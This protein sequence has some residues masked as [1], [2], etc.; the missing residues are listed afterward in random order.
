[1]NVILGQFKPAFP[2]RA[3]GVSVPFGRGAFTLIEL[4]VVIAIIAI[5]AALLLPTLARAKAKAKRIQCLSNQRQLATAAMLY[6]TDAQGL[7]PANGRSDYPDP[8]RRLWVQGYFYDQVSVTNTSYIT[9]PQYA[10]FSEYIKTVNPYVCP[11]DPSEVT[12]YYGVRYPRLRSYEMN[13]YVGWYGQWDSRLSTSYRVFNKQSDLAVNLPAGIF[14]FQDVHP[15]SICWPYFGVYMDQEAYFNFPG[16]AHERG[17]VVAFADGHVEYH[18]WRDRRSIT[19]FSA[20]Y[21]NHWDASPNNPDLAW[22][23]ERTTVPK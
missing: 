23:R 12:D 18:R 20:N 6:A 4:L 19:A 16:S 13:A 7:L 3:P 21:H 22:L 17:G 2:R 15:N 1:M 5:L 10:L 8:Q 9:S 14:L 11:S